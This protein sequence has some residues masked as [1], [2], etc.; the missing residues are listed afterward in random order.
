VVE[1][2]REKRIL[3]KAIKELE[4][5]HAMGKLSAADHAE[6]AGRYR[7]RAI[8]VL[9]QLDAG[10]L[11]YRDLVE[12]ELAARLA[13]AA[14]FNGVCRACR[15]RNDADADFCK[16]CGARLTAEEAGP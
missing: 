14:A 9:R 1:L 3:L 8:A 16:K 7:A 4:F 5:D 15:T 13:E 12:R 11:S 6:I 2:E 10:S